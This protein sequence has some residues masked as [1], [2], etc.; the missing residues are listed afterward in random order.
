MNTSFA[1]AAVL[2]TLAC[3]ARAEPPASQPKQIPLESIYATSSQKPLQHVTDG[4]MPLYDGAG[5]T[6]CAVAWGKDFKSIKAGDL[7]LVPEPGDKKLSIERPAD[8]DAQLWA[9]IFFGTSGSQPPQFLIDSV[10]VEGNRFQLDCHRPTPGPM[11]KDLFTY[12]AW[13]PLGKLP[14]GDYYMLVVE[15]KPV[16][17]R[18]WT[19]TEKATK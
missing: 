10:K 17:G 19:I 4:P 3:I 13:V 15:G 18:G 9:V 16:G 2:L 1:L 7:I 5:P 14:A 8:A 11:T 12:V 6:L